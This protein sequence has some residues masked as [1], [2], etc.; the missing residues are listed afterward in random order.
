[1]K[2]TGPGCDVES[3]VP[4]FSSTVAAK[5]GHDPTKALFPK[6]C[7]GGRVASF[8]IGPGDFQ[9]TEISFAWRKWLL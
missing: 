7:S 2:R 6:Q 1:M 5:G 3:G 9:L 8:Q 4:L